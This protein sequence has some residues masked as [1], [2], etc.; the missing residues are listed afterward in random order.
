MRVGPELEILHDRHAVEDA[1]AFRRLCHP[2]PGD[3]M[4]RFV[5]DQFAAETYGASSRSEKTGDRLQVVVL[6]AP[7]EPIRVTIS[8]WLT[9]SVTPL[10]AWMLP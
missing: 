4:G 1:A 3:D 5:A 6:P 9:W 8:P 7:F 10:S 2:H